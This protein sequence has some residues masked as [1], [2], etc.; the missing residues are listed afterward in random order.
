MVFKKIIGA[1]KINLLSII[2]IIIKINEFRVI[3]MIMICFFYILHFFS[4]RL[5]S[6][7]ISIYSSTSIENLD[8][9]IWGE[10]QEHYEYLMD[11]GLIE[12]CQVCVDVD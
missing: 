5:S 6:D 4:C 9:D 11:K 10:F 7:L 8:E 3:N 12:T 1:T 2:V